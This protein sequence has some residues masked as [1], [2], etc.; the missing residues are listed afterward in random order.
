MDIVISLQNKYINI[1]VVIFYTHS[2]YFWISN[3][4]F[5]VF[6]IG[7][8]VLL[9]TPRSLLQFITPKFTVANDYKHCNLMLKTSTEHA[10][11]S[12]N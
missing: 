12:V 10:N 9:V 4:E 6:I 2:I 3:L 5:T 8:V 1:F 11:V 7:I